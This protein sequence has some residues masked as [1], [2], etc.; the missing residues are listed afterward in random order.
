MRKTMLV[1]TALAAMS[2]PA[3]AA[4]IDIDK[5]G[6][7]AAKATREFAGVQTEGMCH[8]VPG[9][10]RPPMPCICV[11]VKLSPAHYRWMMAN[12]NGWMM[13]DKSESIRTQVFKTNPALIC[14]WQ[15]HPDLGLIVRADGTKYKAMF[16]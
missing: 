13:S 6:A 5:G 3:P 10:G 14:R 8:S 1:L 9:H 15:G 16:R 7:P 2:V 4:D 12:R 11:E